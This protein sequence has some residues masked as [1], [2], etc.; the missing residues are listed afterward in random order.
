MRVREDWEVVGG[1]VGEM[2]VGRSARA[3]VEIVEVPGRSVSMGI[4]SKMV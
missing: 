2:K 1:R 3:E 4:S